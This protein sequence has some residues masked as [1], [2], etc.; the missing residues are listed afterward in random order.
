MLVLA[1]RCICSSIQASTCPAQSLP[2]IDGVNISGTIGNIGYFKMPACTSVSTIKP[3]PDGGAVM[4]TE[5]DNGAIKKRSLLSVK[6]D[7]TKRWQIDSPYSSGGTKYDSPLITVNSNGNIALASN[8]TLSNSNY[9][10]AFSLVSGANGQV[11][12]ANDIMP[13]SSKSV[14]YKLSGSR[15]VA[16]VNGKAY[17]S[18]SNCNYSTNG[19]RPDC[20]GVYA[21]LMT[22]SSSQF[23]IDFPRGTIMQGGFKKYYALGDSFASGESVKPFATSTDEG[24]SSDNDKDTC[25]RSVLA[26]AKQLEQNS[27][28]KLQIPNNGFVACSGAET[29]NIYD[30]YDLDSKFKTEKLQYSQLS[31]DAN[32]V[33]ISIG[34]NDAYFSDFVNSCLFLDCS[35]MQSPVVSRSFNAVA[36]MSGNLTNVYKQIL[37]KAPNAK[38]YVVGYPQIL[39]QKGCSQTDGWMKLFNAFA[40]NAKL[41]DAMS[42]AAINKIGQSASLDAAQ[43]QQLI[44]AGTV[45]FNSGEV[46]TARNLVTQL[47][48]AIKSAVASVGSSRL[49][50]IDPTAAGSPFIGHELCTSNPYFN[51]VVLDLAEVGTDMNVEFS[52]HP[53]LLGVSEG[54]YRLLLPYF[55]A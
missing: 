46:A 10:V 22:L 20:F 41:G 2:L 36:N 3:Q 53:N 14:S 16:L 49:V 8:Y 5:S 27:S 17:I 33:T 44:N 15:S 4:L 42:I 26:Y 55:K 6:A 19:G 1:G 43:I 24:S 9:G 23:A 25:H 21:S 35:N 30:A 29:K 48:A 18:L 32:I 12:L 28:L 51:G 31:S 47:D 11:L 37:Q 50:Y 13:D 40:I 54:Y 38:V 39:P 45:E 7:G 34:G 52:F